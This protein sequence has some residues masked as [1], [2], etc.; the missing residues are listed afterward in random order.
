MSQVSVT[1]SKLSGDWGSCSGGT[2]RQKEL[3][4]LW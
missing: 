1:M 2:A 4:R 3:W